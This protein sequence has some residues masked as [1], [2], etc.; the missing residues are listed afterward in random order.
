MYQLALRAALLLIVSLFAF[1]PAA[2]AQD[3]VD[4]CAAPV[5][6]NKNCRFQIP[7][8]SVSGFGVVYSQWNPFIVSGNV[9]FDADYHGNSYD[10]NDMQNGGREQSIFSRGNGAWR[11]GVFQ[12]VNVTAGN[13]YF[14]RIGWFVSQ[15]TTIMGRVGIDPTGGT[16]PTSSN[17]VWSQSLGLLRQTRIN[18]RGVRAASSRIT[19]FAEAT[20][21]TPFG[22]GDRLWLTAVSLSPDAS[23]APMTATPVPPTVTPSP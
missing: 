14:A 10:P 20:S 4:P 7:T 22:G 19:L 11:A 2:L 6:L 12:Q 3:E 21:N 1:A 18:V 9:G 5:V 23:V 13:G 16:D 17:I 15:N 8:A